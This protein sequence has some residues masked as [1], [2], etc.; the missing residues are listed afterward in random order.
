MVVAVPQLT[1]MAV[2]VSVVFFVF[3]SG[4]IASAGSAPSRGVSVVAQPGVYVPGGL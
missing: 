2:V 4:S 3:A 1:R